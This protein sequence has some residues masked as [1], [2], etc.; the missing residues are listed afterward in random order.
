MRHFKDREDGY[1]VLM[2]FSKQYRSLSPFVNLY[3]TLC[4]S[5]LDWVG[6][7]VQPDEA[8]SRLNLA[9]FL[10]R[11]IHKNRV[12]PRNQTSDMQ[13]F[14]CI[15]NLRIAQQLKEEQ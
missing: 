15:L 11:A 4:S 7:K 5:C 13:V 9:T 6:T 14:A 2:D 3:V 12:G 8:L 1:D 10:Q